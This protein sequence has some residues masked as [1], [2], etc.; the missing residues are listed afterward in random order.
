MIGDHLLDGDLVIVE[1]RNTAK[2]GDLVLACTMN[3]GTAAKRFFRDGPRIRLEPSN[4]SYEALL[5][6]END[7]IIQG[8]VVGILRKYR[9]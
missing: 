9:D 3:E 6:D 4:P 8:V 5:L 1:K 7:V 2:D